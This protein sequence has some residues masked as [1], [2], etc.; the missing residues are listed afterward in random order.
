MPIDYLPI[1]IFLIAVILFAGGTILLSALIGSKKRSKEKLMP[2][3]CGIDPL[4][5]A[6]RRFSVRFYLIAVIFIIFDIEV[7]FLYPWAVIFKKL[8]FFGFVEMAIFIF[9]L[10]IGYLYIWKRGALEWE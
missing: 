6:R 10:L 4:G 9:I 2:Y 1:L 8:K 5:T 7:V 3:E